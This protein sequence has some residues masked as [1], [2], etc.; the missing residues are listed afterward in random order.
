MPF[1][2]LGGDLLGPEIGLEGVG[3]EGHRSSAGWK[4]RAVLARGAGLGFGALWFS[5][6]LLA[7]LL[8]SMSGCEDTECQPERG[9]ALVSIILVGFGGLILGATLWHRRQGR[10]GS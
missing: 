6:T 10:I 9:I 5:S 2:V 7:C 8:W 3:M 4:T 1:Y